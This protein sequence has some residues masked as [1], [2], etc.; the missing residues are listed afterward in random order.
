MV[1]NEGFSSTG[2]LC[3]LS[4][5]KLYSSID[6]PCRCWIDSRNLLFTRCSRVLGDQKMYEMKDWWIHGSQL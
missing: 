3:H 6:D 1:S 4:K 2:L 5:G